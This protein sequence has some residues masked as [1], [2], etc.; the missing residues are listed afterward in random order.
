MGENFAA[1]EYKTQ[2]E[3]LTVI[4]FLTAVLS[5]TGLHILEVLSPSHLLSELHTSPLPAQSIE[6][7]ITVACVFTTRETDNQ[8][9]TAELPIVRTSVIVGIVMLLKAHLKTLYMLS[10]EKCGKFNHTKKSTIG[11]KPALRRH[12]KPITWD[13]LPFAVKPVLTSEDVKEQKERFKKI[14]M[15]DGVTAEPEDEVLQ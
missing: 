11:D 5:T 3:V 1:F 9:C 4:K 8:D 6:T 12:D 15:E 14:W 2:E 10:E 7:E 13:R